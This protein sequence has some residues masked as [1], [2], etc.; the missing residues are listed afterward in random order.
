MTL[1]T[2]GTKVLTAHSC[3]LKGELNIHTVITL[4]LYSSHQALHD[5]SLCHSC[6]EESKI[7][8]KCK[9]GRSSL[10]GKTLQPFYPQQTT[11]LKL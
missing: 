6:Q 7:I 10:M 1:H 2:M 8:V 11:H 5:H 3:C 9:G 4:L